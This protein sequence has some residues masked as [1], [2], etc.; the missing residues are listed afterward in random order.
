MLQ[1]PFRVHRCLFDGASIPCLAWPSKRDFKEA[2]DLLQHAHGIAQSLGVDGIVVQDCPHLDDAGGEYLRV[3]QQIQELDDLGDTLGYSYMAAACSNKQMGA[4]FAAVKKA[5]AKQSTH[6]SKSAERAD[7][8][9]PSEPTA[10]A[11][12]DSVEQSLPP[13][14]ASEDAVWPSEPAGATDEM[15]WP[16]MPPADAA[17]DSVWPSAAP[18]GAT[19]DSVLPSTPL[20]GASMRSVWLSASPADTIEKSDQLHVDTTLNSVWP[21]AVPAD[22]KVDS[23]WPSTVPATGASMDSSW[24]SVPPA[25]AFETPEWPSVTPAEETVDV[26]WPS[27]P[28][29]G[30]TEK[31]GVWPSMASGGAAVAVWGPT[32]FE[33]TKSLGKVDNTVAYC[34]GAFLAMGEVLC[35]DRYIM[36][37]VHVVNRAFQR[38]P[39][40]M[41][42]EFDFPHMTL[43]K[44]E[45]GESEHIGDETIWKSA[46]E[47]GEINITRMLTQLNHNIK[48]S[49][50]PFRLIPVHVR[51]C[52]H[53]ERYNITG[54]VSPVVGLRSNPVQHETCKTLK[55]NP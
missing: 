6:W 34:P 17:L 52:W 26:Q 44:L 22:A 39:L 38:A 4:G 20:A 23:D 19:V 54:R 5:R 27:A 55:S 45:S 40:A 33:F 32:T 47:S 29:A 14:A 51:Q 10:D 3:L 37:Q 1:T 30:A 41:E 21:S 12:V 11:T 24:P 15:V 50:L 48:C 25:A 13:A 35:L 28:P 18:V 42:S 9:Q 46:V 53:G 2:K 8:V 43:A 7:S 16:S 36:M 31:A 49:G